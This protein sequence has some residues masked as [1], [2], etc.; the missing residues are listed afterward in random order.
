MYYHLKMKKHLLIVVLLAVLCA[1]TPREQR[2]MSP[3]KTL[4]RAEA[5]MTQAPD[6]ALMLLEDLSKG[7]LRG[8]ENRAHF[9]L[10]YSQALDKN[11]IDRS[12]DSII[13]VAVD[14]YSTR[15]KEPEKLFLSY[16][17]LGRV[18]QNAG[19]LTRAMLSYGQ[20]EEL[21]ADIQ[22]DYAIGLMYTQMGNLYKAVYDLPKSLDCFQKAYIHYEKADKELHKMYAKRD[23]GILY[24]N[25]KR[26]DIAEDC[27]IEVLNW[28]QTAMMW[29]LC[30]D[31][32]ESLCF[33][34]IE[35]ADQQKLKQLY[36]RDIFKV[37]ADSLLEIRIASY[38]DIGDNQT[39]AKLRLKKGWEFAT[40]NTDSMN[41]LF[42]EYVY[43]KSIGQY[44]D[45]LAFHEQ[46]LYAQDTLVRGVLQQPLLS[47]QRDYFKSQSG[48][49]ELKL[50]HNKQ[51]QIFASI[52]LL[53]IMLGAVVFIR[54]RM[55][56]K[57]QEIN[58]YAE[59]MKDLEDELSTKD[60]RL[61]VVSQNQSQMAEQVNQLFATQYGLINQLSVTCYEMH[62][63]RNEKEAVYKRVKKEIECFSSN[64]ETLQELE[65]IVNQHKNNVMAVFREKFPEFSEMDF[66][67]ICYSIAGFSAKAISVFTG[68]STTNIYTRKSRLKAII[69]DSDYINKEELLK[70]LLK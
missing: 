17:Y 3:R 53:I 7:A 35:T 48:L 62:A 21:I 19:N 22:D 20:A 10:L 32:I 16:Y 23:V 29:K 1:C 61:H 57:E 67:L 2:N 8:R 43:N 55:E 44:K 70:Y 69:A 37:C 25:M 14:Y 11:Y 54:Q 51:K 38:C 40:N 47:A 41:L 52:I 30:G 58:H 31:C 36:H 6:S 39:S 18:Q 13:R 45:A 12:N 9:A 68:N 42:D 33:I 28:A 63:T 49:N 64:K 66:R 65:N 24:M 50:Q 34:Y 4:S 5:M 59:R 27:L 26:F 60:H 15:K 46:L 56:A